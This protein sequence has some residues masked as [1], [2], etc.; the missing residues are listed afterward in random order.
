M[1]RGVLAAAVAISCA[2]AEYSQQRDRA[3]QIALVEP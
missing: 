3:R 1:P 2:R